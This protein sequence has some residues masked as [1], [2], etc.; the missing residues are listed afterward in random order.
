MGCLASLSI[1]ICSS[2]FQMMLADF[3]EPLP[4]Q[5]D[6]RHASVI[7]I[8]NDLKERSLVDEPA[9]GI[10]VKIISGKNLRP[11]RQFLHRHPYYEMF[12]FNIGSGVIFNNFQHHE[13]SAA[14]LAFISPGRM[15]SWKMSPETH[16]WLIAFSH[17]FLIGSGDLNSEE[18]SLPYFSH[19]LNN[20]VISVKY[21]QRLELDR[22]CTGMLHEFEARRPF[23]VI[24]LRSQL[25]LLLLQAARLYPSGNLEAASAST[26]ITQEFLILLDRS[27]TTIQRVQD[28]A[29]KL[30]ITPH[31]LIEC[32]REKSGRTPGEIIDERLLLEGK[33]LLFYSDKTIAEIAYALSFKDPSHFGHFFKRHV[34]CSPGQARKR[35]Q[36]PDS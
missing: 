7:P 10:I 16:G 9:A 23:R 6:L 32:V 26:R 25:R 21:Q 11:K 27:F 20:P 8:Y 13:F 17:E 14:S 33:R 24:A 35:F 30:K 2:N 18:A 36:H 28:Y 5:K 3:G 15:H 34:G 31:R 4:I 22:I 1:K 12:W 19:L 29:L